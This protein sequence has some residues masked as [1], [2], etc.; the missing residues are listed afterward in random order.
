[1]LTGGIFTLPGIASPF[2]GPLN[3]YVQ[4][5]RSFLNEFVPQAV[6]TTTFCGR[7]QAVR[8]CSAPVS[9]PGGRTASTMRSCR[10]RPR[11]GRGTTSA[12]MGQDLHDRGARAQ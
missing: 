9:W 10:R 11:P 6:E 7:I 5:D 3:D 12:A 1:M 4:R 2:F 8:W